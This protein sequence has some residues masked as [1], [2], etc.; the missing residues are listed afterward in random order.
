M[1][2]CGPGANVGGRVPECIVDGATSILHIVFLIAASAIIIVL[3]ACG[4]KPLEKSWVLFVGHKLRSVLIA[5]LLALN[6]VELVEGALSDTLYEGIHP[7]LYAPHALAILAAVIA[8][9][10]THSAENYNR[11]AHLFLLL[12]YWTAAIAVKAAKIYALVEKDLSSAHSRFNLEIVVIVVYAL[13]FIVEIYSL[14][15]Q[16]SSDLI[17]ILYY[18]I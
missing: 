4:K 17:H 8:I 15:E 1:E 10:Y 16:V 12:L 5:V 3:H 2:F 13:L 18:I 14:R 11:P 9:I 7:H 6:V